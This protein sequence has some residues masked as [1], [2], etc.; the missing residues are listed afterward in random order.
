MLDGNELLAATPE[1]EESLAHEEINLL[2]QVS[3]LNKT[4]AVLE[5]NGLKF[6][7]IKKNNYNRFQYICHDH[8][9]MQLTA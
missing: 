1:F 8:S 7:N 4:A 6:E 9:Q 3:T 2:I 5:V